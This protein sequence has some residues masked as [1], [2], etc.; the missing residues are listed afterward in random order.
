MRGVM[1]TNTTTLSIAVFTFV[2]FATTSAF[3]KPVPQWPQYALDNC[4]EG[5]VTVQYEV[6]EN[7]TVSDV[8]IV[9]ADPEGVFEESAIEFMSRFSDDDA[10]GTIKTEAIHWRFYGGCQFREED[11]T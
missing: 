6:G 5:D 7:Y 9:V 11:E 8:V 4:I 3:S 10:P 2:V 1:F